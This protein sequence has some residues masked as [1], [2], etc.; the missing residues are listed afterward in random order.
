M[1]SCTLLCRRCVSCQLIINHGEPGIIFERVSHHP[2]LP[3]DWKQLSFALQSFGGSWGTSWSRW[4]IFSFLLFFC[5]SLSGVCYIIAS[6]YSH[7]FSKVS[8]RVPS[9]FPFFVTS[10]AEWWTFLD[11]KRPLLILIYHCW[12]MW[13]SNIRLTGETRLLLAVLQMHI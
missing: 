11:L 9:L 1:G 13:L 5:V 8:S 3:L 2:L 6:V 10:R 7:Y 12:M 4:V